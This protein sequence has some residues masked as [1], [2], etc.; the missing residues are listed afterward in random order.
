[1]KAILI[2][3]TIKYLDKSGI[4]PLDWSSPMNRLGRLGVMSRMVLIIP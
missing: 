4:S 1:M 2:A 3:Q